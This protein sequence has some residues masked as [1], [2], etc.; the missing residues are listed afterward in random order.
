MVT[1]NSFKYVEPEVLRSGYGWQRVSAERSFGRSLSFGGW[2]VRGEVFGEVW[3]EVLGEVFRLVLLGHSEKKLHQKVH[4]KSPT[5]LRS[6]IG[7][8]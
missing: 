4:L 3:R 5:P 1:K 6:K 7:E 2:A 8:N